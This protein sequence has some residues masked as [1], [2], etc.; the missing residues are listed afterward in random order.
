[1][2][3][4]YNLDTIIYKEA[5]KTRLNRLTTWQKFILILWLMGWKQRD[6]AERVYVTTQ[7]ISFT[8]NEAKKRMGVYYQWEN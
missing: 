7:S 1:M 5:L 8:I 3:N 2:N 6:I 4:N